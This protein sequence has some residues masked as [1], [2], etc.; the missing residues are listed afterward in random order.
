[1]DDIIDDATVRAY[2]LHCLEALRVGDRLMAEDE[3][4]GVDAD[5]RLAVARAIME[6]YGT[7]MEEACPFRN[8]LKKS[9]LAVVAKARLILTPPASPRVM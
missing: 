8:T 2:Y 9:E 6:A 3:A 4:N 1:M 5:G 7:L